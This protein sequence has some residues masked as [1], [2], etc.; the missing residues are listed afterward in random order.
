MRA[1]FGFGPRGPQGGAGAQNAPSP[2]GPPPEG[3]GPPP[4]GRRGGARGLGGGGGGGLSGPRS[5]GRL[6][7]S[8]AATNPLGDPGGHGPGRAKTG[9]LHGHPDSAYHGD[10]RHTS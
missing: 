2:P 9:S 5:R 10:G 8:P 1:Q 6:Q 7:V 4:E 3:A